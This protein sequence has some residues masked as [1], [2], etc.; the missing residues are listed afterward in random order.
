MQTEILHRGD[1]NG[2]INAYELLSGQS[3]GEFRVSI[4]ALF[5]PMLKA[6]FGT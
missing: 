1:K 6:R 5:F 4:K 2:V 3:R